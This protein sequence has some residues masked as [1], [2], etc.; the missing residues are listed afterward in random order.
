LL[1]RRPFGT[2]IYIL[3]RLDV[4]FRSGVSSGSGRRDPSA[5][6]V[7]F[8]P[9]TD[10]ML[11]ML[12]VCACFV[13]DIEHVMPERLSRLLRGTAL[14]C[15]PWHR[16]FSICDAQVSQVM[17]SH[18]SGRL[19]RI[20]KLLSK[21]IDFATLASTRAKRGNASNEIISPLLQL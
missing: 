8:S 3:R 10:L 17:H 13:I 19:Q 12:S 16:D 15:T 4:G 14:I 2:Y 9:L 5:E 21:I 7:R 20:F 6:E 18:G 11:F 1:R